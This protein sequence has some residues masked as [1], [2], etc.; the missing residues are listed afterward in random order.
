M[1]EVQYRF[2]ENQED[3]ELRLK[4]VW[5]ELK[6]KNAIGGIDAPTPQ[7]S[8]ELNKKIS[9]LVRRIRWRVD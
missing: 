8:L 7:E 9:E 6:R 4:K 5:I 3:K 1:L 2:W